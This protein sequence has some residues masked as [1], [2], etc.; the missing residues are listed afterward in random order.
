VTEQEGIGPG[1]RHRPAAKALGVIVCDPDG[2]GFPDLI[3][4]NDTVRNFFFH[5][6]PGPD[7]TRVFKA[8]GTKVGLGLAEG[9]ARGRLGMDWGE[10]MP[11]EWAVVIAN[12]ANEPTT[13]FC[14]DRQATRLRFADLAVAVGISGPTLGPLKFGTFF[15]DY[16]LDGR[17]DLLTNNGHLEPDI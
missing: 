3:V 13:F 2:D 17:L 7:G 6:V 11:G 9:S 5:N 16:D 14:Q 4:A 8:E 15:L 1:A 12:F 10:F